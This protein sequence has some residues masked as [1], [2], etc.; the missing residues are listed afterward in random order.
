MS[1]VAAGRGL[2]GEC[3]WTSFLHLAASQ[4]E[5]CHTGN[6]MNTYVK[7]RLITSQK[8]QLLK[9]DANNIDPFEKTKLLPC[10]T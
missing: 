2:T 3:L 10:F 5:S 4:I 1:T 9:K 8:R 7:S 6:L